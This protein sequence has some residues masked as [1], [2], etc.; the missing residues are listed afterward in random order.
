MTLIDQKGDPARCP[1]VSP[2]PSVRTNTSSEPFA[3]KIQGHPVVTSHPVPVGSISLSQPKNPV[4]QV[5]ALSLKN[6]V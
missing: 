5:L 1:R 3:R 4:S 2:S 6:A